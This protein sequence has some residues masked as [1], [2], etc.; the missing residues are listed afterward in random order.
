MLTEKPFIRLQRLQVI[1]VVVYRADK[2]L[3]ESPFVFGSLASF[4]NYRG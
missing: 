4:S 2:H 3:K 1:T